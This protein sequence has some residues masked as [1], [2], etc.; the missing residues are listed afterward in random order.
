[1][2]RGGTNVGV[3]DTVKPPSRLDSGGATQDSGQ[4]ALIPFSPTVMSER[5]VARELLAVGAKLARC[6]ADQD[7]IEDIRSSGIAKADGL[8]PELA[9]E[10]KCCISL[11]ADLASQGWDI[12]IQGGRIAVAAPDAAVSPDQRKAQVRAGHH[13]GRDAQLATPSVRRFIAD[14]E[15][16]RPFK[17][18]W[19]SI[20]SVMRDGREL[21]ALC[22]ATAA[23]PDDQREA[24]IARC[25]DP[26]IQTV[27][28][29]AACEFTGLRLIDV[30]RYFRHTWTTAYKSTPG[31]KMHFLIRDRAAPNHPVIG[32]GALGSGIV[33]LSARDLWI[34]WT[35]VG[36][37]KRM[38][39]TPTAIWARW[40]DRSLKDLIAGRRT[41]DLLKRAKLTASVLSRP[42]P[43][44][45]EKLSRLA[46]TA[47]EKHRHTPQRG[48][49]KSASAQRVADWRA[50]SETHL[51]VAKRA[52]SLVTLLAAK[53]SLQRAG[54]VK[55]TLTNF[56]RALEDGAARR[57]IEVVARHVKARHVGVDMMDITVC[58]AVAPYGAIL[59]GK[60]VSLLMASPTVVRAY[61]DRYTNSPSI[62]ASAM[63]G[64]AVRRRPRLVLLGTTS[65]YDVAPS[66][67]NR[68]KVPGVAFGANDSDLAFLRIGE[69]EGYGSHHFSQTTN[70]LLARLA[71]RG[72]NGRRVNSIFGEGVSPKFRKVRGALDLLGLS[73]D[74]LLQHGSARA[75]YAVP[76]ATNFR[77]VLIGSAKVPKYILPDVDL[78]TKALVSYWRKRWLA[79]R[80]LRPEV[81]EALGQHRLA[82]PV[83]H[84]ARVRLPEIGADGPLFDAN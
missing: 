83:V 13:V 64:T 10:A 37:L 77:D 35:G 18:H 45:L 25:V 80:I 33:Q 81:A 20:F 59:G 82:F 9:T 75:I 39:D 15:R 5:H 2:N 63:A 84:G 49:H 29:E 23:L 65:L 4:V 8:G 56:R 26:Y 22:E 16:A 67:Y 36:V 62:I 57:A 76:L 42:T 52:E 79:K 14:L 31:R 21:A 19:H 7:A 72:Q 58:G 32:I 66:Q 48:R 68:L 71:A 46:A 73:S 38:S 44:A 30:W 69:T 11:L 41:D 47:R 34:G 43:Q 60:L 54:F 74:R 6:S 70:E 3:R 28:S 51:F 27:T 78:G 40:L 50:L 1:M 17:G 55:P 61:N 12:V 24:A 53:L